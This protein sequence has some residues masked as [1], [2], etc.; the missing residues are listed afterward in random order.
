MFTLGQIT[1]SPGAKVCLGLGESEVLLNRHVQ[2]DYGDIPLVDQCINDQCVVEGGPITS[3]YRS[4]KG[5]EVVIVTENNETSISLTGER[6]VCS[7]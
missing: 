6:Y 1:V 3:I 7:K 4:R 5:F 2:G